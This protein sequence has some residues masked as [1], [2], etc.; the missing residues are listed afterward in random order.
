MIYQQLPFLLAL[1]YSQVETRS[2]DADSICRCPNV[3]PNLWTPSNSSEI[4][5]E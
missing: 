2:T 5:E 3:G 4:N 1:P